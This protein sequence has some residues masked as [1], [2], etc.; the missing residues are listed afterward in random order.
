MSSVFRR[1][2]LLCIQLLTS[3]GTYYRPILS[4]FTFSLRLTQPPITLKSLFSMST[5][6]LT[7]AYPAAAVGARTYE[8][9]ITAL[10]TLQSNASILAAIRSSGRKLNDLSLVEMRSYLSRI[11]YSPSDLIPL[12]LIHISGTKGKGSTCAFTSWILTSHAHLLPANK[13][14]VGLY[15]SPHLRSV[16]ERIRINNEPISRDLFAKYF[17]EV[18]DRLGHAAEERGTEDVGGVARPMYFRFL[19]LMAFHVFVSEGMGVVVLE[20]GIGGEFDSTNIIEQPVCTGVTRLGIDHVAVLGETLGEISWHKAGIFKPGS[21]AFS[22]AQPDEAR[23]VLESRAKERGVL[24]GEVRWVKEE[25]V[26]PP[27]T[28]LGLQGGFQWGNA[29]LAV[30]VASEALRVITAGEVDYAKTHLGKGELPELVRRG[31]R[32]TVWA[33]RCQVLADERLGNGRLV[34]CLDGA[35]TVDSLEAAGRWFVEREGGI[36]SQQSEHDDGRVERKKRIRI[37]L[38]NQQTRDAATL[39]KA[40]HR[41]VTISVSTHPFFTHVI[42]TTN[43]TRRTGYSADLVSNGTSTSDVDNLTVQRALEQEWG[44]LNSGEGGAKR[45]LCGSIEE[46]VEKIRTV[47]G[48]EGGEGVVLCTGSLHLVGGALEVLDET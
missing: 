48:E 37:L 28:K 40:L 39:L 31:L 12:N 44:V 19:T 7:A 42:F 43:V 23:G 2:P 5:S 20:V 41:T 3:G 35:H 38:F 34:W 6:S 22:V 24:G 13:E 36:L 26:L 9:A 15:T 25:E 8:D 29:A 30:A 27:D 10:N 16:R 47:V 32:E 14:K 18:W 17:W 11:G 1:G 45:W 21:A 46:A 4:T 33:G